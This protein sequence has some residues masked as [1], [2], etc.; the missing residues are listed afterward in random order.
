MNDA[1]VKT[2][3]PTFGNALNVAS[4]AYGFSSMAPFALSLSRELPNSVFAIQLASN[5]EGAVPPA[6]FIHVFLTP[7]HMLLRICNVSESAAFI[8]GT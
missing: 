7:N 4:S 8:V 1:P 6:V 5:P 2:G 3:E